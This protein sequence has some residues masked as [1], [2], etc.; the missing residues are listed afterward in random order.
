MRIGRGKGRAWRGAALVFAL[1]V[2][3][4]AHAGAETV[5]PEL[6][7]GETLKSVSMPTGAPLKLDGWTRSGKATVYTLDVKKGKTYRLRFNP[8]SEYAY[9][10]IFDLANP[11]DEAMYSSDVNGKEAD[12]RANA[13]TTWLIRPY[14][15]RVAPRRGLG[16][17]YSIEISTK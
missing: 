4:A 11:N 2:S 3:F 8:S 13:D 5:E 10:I 16:A 15:S 9:L 1:I 12:L 6:Y 14:F 17:R 7:E